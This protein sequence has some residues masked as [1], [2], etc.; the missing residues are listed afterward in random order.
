MFAL[1]APGARPNSQ[2]ERISYLM[3]RHASI[4][5]QSTEHA[6]AV[7]SPYSVFVSSF[8]CKV[9]FFPFTYLGF[10]LFVRS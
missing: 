2:T 6:A 8:S 3:E 10:S 4:P 1:I 7:E 5:A 9:L